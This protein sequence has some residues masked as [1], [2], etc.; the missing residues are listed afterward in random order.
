MDQA[1]PGDSVN[2]RAG[3]GSGVLERL[4]GPEVSWVWWRDLGA[5]RTADSV[6]E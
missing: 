4:A 3:S 5:S 1:G 2:E 6:D